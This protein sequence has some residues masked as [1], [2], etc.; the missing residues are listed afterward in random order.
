MVDRF[1]RSYF[2]LGWRGF[3]R[4]WAISGRNWESTLRAAVEKGP[5]FNLSPFS[6]ID[7]IVLREGYY[8]SEVV[9]A[10]VSDLGDGVFWDVGSNFGLHAI[11]A[12][13]L[14]PSSRVFSFEPSPEMLIRIS[15]NR[16]LNGLEIGILGIGL[17]DRPGIETL[18][19]GPAG[20]P[21]MSTLSP[22]SEAQYSGKLTVAV[23]T[24]DDLVAQGVIPVPT[25]MKIDVEGHEHQV[26]EGM[27]RILSSV[28][29]RT[30]VFEDSPD[31]GTRTKALLRLLIKDWGHGAG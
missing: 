13:F 14:R 17:S 16:D 5:V 10:I 9:E 25:V 11:T 8:E 21:G 18:F 28:T 6:H 24:G 7:S 19:L 3:F 23:A 12:K 31:D 26:L 4:L 27:K 20:N 22:W 2:K 15:R 29:L 30:V 1:L